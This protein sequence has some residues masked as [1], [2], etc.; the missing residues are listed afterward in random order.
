[1]NIEICDEA[2]AKFMSEALLS[3]AREICRYAVTYSKPL[4]PGAPNDPAQRER[5]VGR[6]ERM[7]KEMYALMLMAKYKG[8]SRYCNKEQVEAYMDETT[9]ILESC[10]IEAQAMPSMHD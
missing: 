1:M 7:Q 9:A 2:T 3:H 6:V 8:I 10:G 5:F 4:V